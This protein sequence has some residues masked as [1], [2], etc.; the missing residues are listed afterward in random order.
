MIPK[1]TCVCQENEHQLKRIEH[2][3]RYGYMN[4]HG[5][6]ECLIGHCRFWGIAIQGEKC[7][8]PPNSYLFPSSKPLTFWGFRA[9]YFR[10]THEALSLKP[11]LPTGSAE[12]CKL[13]TPLTC[14]ERQG[15]GSQKPNHSPSYKRTRLGGA[16][17]SFVVLWKMCNNINVRYVMSDKKCVIQDWACWTV[18]Q[19]IKVNATTRWLSLIIPPCDC[20][21]TRKIA[22]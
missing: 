10:Q 14:G 2:H 1:F 16:N 19:C 4:M 12:S 22:I 15:D 7:W 9:I 13:E 3:K 6:W 8:E 11:T 17:E 21:S 5:S 20:V 18:R